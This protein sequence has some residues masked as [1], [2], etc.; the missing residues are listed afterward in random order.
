MN[1]NLTLAVHI[2][3]TIAYVE[4]HEQRP[5]TSGE[6]ARCMGASSV[7]VRRI[8]LKLQQAGLLTSKRGPSGGSS[9]LRKP[10]D[11]NLRQVW[12]AVMV[13]DALRP[14]GPRPERPDC[15][16]VSVVIRDYLDGVYAQAQCAFLSQL[17]HTSLQKMIDHIT[18]EVT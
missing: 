7:V 15:E 9:L 2:L 3:G 18:T 6:L 10:Q 8:L 17:E 14:A 13:E 11:I 12:E 1:Q 16:A 5:V 4:H